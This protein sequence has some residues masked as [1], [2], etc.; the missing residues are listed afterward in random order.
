MAYILG[1]MSHGG[2][3]AEHNYEDFVGPIQREGDLVAVREYQ[4]VFGRRK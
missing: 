4:E 3:F 1:N 2:E